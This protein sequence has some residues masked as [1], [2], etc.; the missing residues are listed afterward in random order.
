MPELG[1]P[2][3]GRQETGEGG[4]LPQGGEGAQE[5]GDSVGLSHGKE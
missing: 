4:E 2:L 3:N 5:A 1:S